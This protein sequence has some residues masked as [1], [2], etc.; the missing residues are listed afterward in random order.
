MAGKYCNRNSSDL[1]GECGNDG[2]IAGML[3]LHHKANILGYLSIDPCPTLA[4]RIYVTHTP[5]HLVLRE[6]NG[7]GMNR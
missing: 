4:A 3:Y 7:A 1:Q 5:P 6:R 2:G